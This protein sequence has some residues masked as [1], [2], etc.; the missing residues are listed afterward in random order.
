MRRAQGIR[1]CGIEH[2]RT[3]YRICR[4]EDAGAEVGRIAEYVPAIAELSREADVIFEVVSRPGDAGLGGK[5]VVDLPPFHHLRKTFFRWQVPRAAQRETVAD[6]QVA[7]A[8]LPPR[9]Q[10]VLGLG[11]AVERCVVDR[12]RIG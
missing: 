8:S 6:I 4:R 5:D 7:A 9:E 11:G 2:D 12:V 10:A 3:V 1:A